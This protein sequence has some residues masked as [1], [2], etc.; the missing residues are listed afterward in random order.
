M[1]NHC[2][3]ILSL[4]GKKVELEK[5]YEDNQNIYKDD[6]GVE[7]IESFCFNKAVPIEDEENGY[8]ERIDRWGTKWEPWEIEISKDYSEKDNE[9]LETSIQYTF[10]TAWSPPKEW[11][12]TVCPRY[13]DIIF[14]LSYEDEAL[15]FWGEQEFHG[16]E[17][18]NVCGF[19]YEEMQDYFSDYKNIAPEDVYD[20]II[21]KDYDIRKILIKYK[22]VN[23]EYRKGINIIEDTS[24]EEDSEDGWET[25]NSEDENNSDDED[26]GS[27]IN[28][29]E[30]MDEELLDILVDYNYD[31]ELFHSGRVPTQLL[32]YLLE[33]L[34]E[35]VK[36]INII[37]S[38]I[39]CIFS[40]KELE[41]I[42]LQKELCNE[43]LVTPP[44]PNGYPGG[45]EYHRAMERFMENIDL[46]R[47][48]EK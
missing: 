35:S 9:D 21:K 23:E 24:N 41:R 47:K 16:E 1:P 29:E 19:T 15:C 30:N 18:I 22:L 38:R 42:R 20:Y 17:V 33:W 37:Q 43:I 40:V 32:R 13:P 2:Y 3:N 5:F 39:R 45:I 10:E 14:N 28:D 8:Y 36:G 44:L 46:L 25:I 31:M 6:D 48:V 26:F 7:K 12:E 4:S 11:L 27:E 34:H